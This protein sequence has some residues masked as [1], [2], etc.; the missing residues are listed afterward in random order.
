MDTVSDELNNA[1]A[2]M[3]ANNPDLWPVFAPDGTARHQIWECADGWLVG[4]TTEKVDGGP[5]HGKFAV[6][7]Y[8]PMGKGARSGR[9]KAFHH[10]R[11]YF[12]SFAKRKTAR[13]RAVAMYNQH[14]A[15][16]T[17]SEG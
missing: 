3:L 14:N 8:K 2:R 17:A 6:M 7:A 5:H 12:R 16:K 11:V 4:Y 10:K 9:G 15:K 1:M 13:A